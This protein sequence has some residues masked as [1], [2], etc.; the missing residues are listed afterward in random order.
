MKQKRISRALR[1]RMP[2]A[3]PASDAVIDED[4]PLCQAMPEDIETPVFCHLDG[5][6]MDDCFEFSFHRT[7]DEWE[8]EQKRWEEFNSRNRSKV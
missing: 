6:G 1:R 4:C 2:M 5:S 3:V 8:A 7:R